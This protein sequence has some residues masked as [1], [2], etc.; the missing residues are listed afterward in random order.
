MAKSDSGSKL[1]DISRTDGECP[2]SCGLPS[3]RTYLL[4]NT[5]R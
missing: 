1:S 2:V 4:S 3:G 5:T